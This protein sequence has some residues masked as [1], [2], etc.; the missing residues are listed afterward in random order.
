MSAL[1]ALKDIYG[2]V[3]ADWLKARVSLFNDKNDTTYWQIIAEGDASQKWFL[4]AYL[5]FVPH[6]TLS[7]R[8]KFIIAEGKH[9]GP[10]R[11]WLEFDKWEGTKEDAD[12]AYKLG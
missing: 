8:R 11:E 5:E 6:P 9:P 3:P 2:Y 7:H 10:I 1:Q 4:R 12:L